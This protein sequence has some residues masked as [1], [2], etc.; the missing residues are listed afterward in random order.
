[1][2]FYGILGDLPEM[3]MANSLLWLENHDAMNGLTSRISTGPFSI[4]MLVYQRVTTDHYGNLCF[5]PTVAAHH[6]H[7]VQGH[8][9]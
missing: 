2:G 4:V 5:F 6:V 3:V 9:Y 1:M 8:A 7:D